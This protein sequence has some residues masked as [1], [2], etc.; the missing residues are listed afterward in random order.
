MIHNHRGSDGTPPRKYAVVTNNNNEFVIEAADDIEAGY[1]AINLVGL[2]EE[3]D[4]VKDVIP[5]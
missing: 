1:R 4:E 3:T 5:L 2:L